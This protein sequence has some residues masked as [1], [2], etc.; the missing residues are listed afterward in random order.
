MLGRIWSIVVDQNHDQTQSNRRQ[1]SRDKR[2]EDRSVEPAGHHQVG[3]RKHAQA[4]EETEIELVAPPAQKLIEHLIGQGG[5]SL[6]HGQQQKRE[7][8]RGDG[9][10]ACGNRAQQAAERARITKHIAF[11]FDR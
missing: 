3:Q 9:D 7:G 6:L 5:C 11:A 8:D 4:H 10:Q 2:A 1:Q